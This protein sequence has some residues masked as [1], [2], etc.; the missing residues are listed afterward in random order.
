MLE[1]LQQNSQ[2]DWRDLVGS[3]DIRKESI[4]NMPETSNANGH[5]AELTN[6][7]L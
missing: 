5:S 7:Q 3:I 6:F 4:S 1:V 2:I